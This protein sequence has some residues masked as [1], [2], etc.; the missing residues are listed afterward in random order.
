M[1]TDYI[2]LYQTH[3][4][5]FTTA[6]ED[7]MAAL[8]SLK[9]QGKIRAI[10]VSNATVDQMKEYGEIDTDQEKYSMIHRNKDD[11]GNS[12]YCDENDI[13]I[14][15][16]SPLG[17]GLLT[18]KITVDRKYNEGDVRLGSPLFAK[19][20]VN[21]INSMLEE[22][23]PIAEAHDCNVGQLSLAWTYNR[24]GISH[25]LCGARN[26]QQALDNAMAGEINLSQQDI[27]DIDTIYSKYF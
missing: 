21:R 7:T 3:W 1:Q 20:N 22:F 15:A 4:Q 16:Y 12:A 6:I 9:D 24:K 5:E 14:L 17:Q 25:L 19:D 11:E 27:A 23:T 10:G 26:T 8:L 18:G 13:A 2:D